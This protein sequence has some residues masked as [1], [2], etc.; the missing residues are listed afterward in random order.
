MSRALQ[1]AIQRGDM[2]RRRNDVVAGL[3]AIHVIIRIDQTLSPRLPPSDFSRAVGND[4][5]RVHVLEV[6]EPV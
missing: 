3:A 2:H 1:I 4:F 6:P 5:I